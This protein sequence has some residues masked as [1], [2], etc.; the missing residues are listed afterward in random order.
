MECHS[1]AIL[2]T[3]KSVFPHRGHEWRQHLTWRH[4]LSW[5]RSRWVLGQQ[6]VYMWTF[7]Q[8]CEVSNHFKRMMITWLPHY[9]TGGFCIFFKT[10]TRQNSYHT[11]LFTWNVAHCNT[12]MTIKSPS[13]FFPRTHISAHISACV[14][15][16][17]SWMAAHQRK[18]HFNKTELMIS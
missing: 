3:Q 6:N 4:G 14:T 13:P 15:D 11:Y 9:H 16:I 8:E 1:R 10:M 7:F 5:G 12:K 18:L 2:N 17:S